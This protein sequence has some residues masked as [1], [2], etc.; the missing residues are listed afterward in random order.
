MGCPSAPFGLVIS[1]RGAVAARKQVN[2]GRDARRLETGAFFFQL[3]RE[4]FIYLSCSP[5]ARLKRELR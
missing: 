4:L 3:A 2:R 1:D 5:I